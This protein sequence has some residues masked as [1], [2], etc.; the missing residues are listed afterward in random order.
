MIIFIQGSVDYY[1]GDLPFTEKE[2][3]VELGEAGYRGRHFVLS[4][5]P[6]LDKIRHRADLS[7][8][9]LAYFKR[10]HNEFS[11]IGGIGRGVSRYLV[12]SP[13]AHAPVMRGGVWTVPLSTFSNDEFSQS[14]R[15]ICEN[16]ND[17]DVYSAL[18]E[19]FVGKTHPGFS[20]SIK[21]LPGGGGGT[22]GVLRRFL[23]EPN[24]IGLCVLDSDKSHRG[25]AEGATARG[26]R[27]EWFEN[28]RV[29]L[30]VIAARELE[31]IIPLDL[32]KAYLSETRINISGMDDFEKLPNELARYICLKTGEA[33]CRFFGADVR[34][35]DGQLTV[36]ALEQAGR[37][38]HHAGLCREGCRNSSCYM[39]PQYGVNFLASF[40]RWLQSRFKMMRREVHGW[41]TELTEILE[42]IVA[43]GLALPVKR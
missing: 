20:L 9:S 6:I 25:G 43:S 15:I 19:I 22:A 32:V 36:R 42:Q 16:D 12:A 23:V 29:G 33:I 24:P 7:P 11:Q 1:S 2:S 28:W 38:L 26:C 30:N 40:G 41:P 37:V 34:T 35:A 13:D 3:L 8:R 27:S 31:N 4:T 39:A 18:A 5:Y 10:V 21:S 17:F 14:S